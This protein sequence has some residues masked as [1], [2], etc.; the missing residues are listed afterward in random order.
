MPNR[1]IFE[2]N[3]RAAI[4]ESRGVVCGPYDMTAI[5]AEIEIEENGEKR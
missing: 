4:T 1:T 3:R 2:Q 5:D